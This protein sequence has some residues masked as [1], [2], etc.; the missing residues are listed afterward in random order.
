MPG[1]SQ[2]AHVGGEPRTDQTNV[3][4]TYTYILDRMDS[5]QVSYSYLLV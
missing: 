5:F 3:S 1:P 2:G 4:H